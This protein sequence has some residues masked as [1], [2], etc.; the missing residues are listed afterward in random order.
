MEL[1]D[2][3]QNFIRPTPGGLPT[4]LCFVTGFINCCKMK[5]PSLSSEACKARSAQSPPTTAWKWKS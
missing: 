4:G 2:T 5:I 1:P 3:I